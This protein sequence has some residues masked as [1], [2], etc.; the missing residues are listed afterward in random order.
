MLYDSLK[1]DKDLPSTKQILNFL[2]KPMEFRLESYIE[3]F[4]SLNYVHEQGIALNDIKPSNI[5]CSKPSTE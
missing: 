4:D 5:M 1:F 3:L 2:K